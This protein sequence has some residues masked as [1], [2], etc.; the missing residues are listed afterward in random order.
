MNSTRRIHLSIGEGELP[1]TGFVSRV[2]DT[3][4][5]A[6]RTSVGLEDEELTV[7]PEA[8]EAIGAAAGDDVGFTPAMAETGDSPRDERE[9]AAT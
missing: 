7:S 5:R 4:F 6:V 3:G 2:T 9:K 1:D 8:A